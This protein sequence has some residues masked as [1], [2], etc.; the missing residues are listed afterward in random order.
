M[1]E[2]K[3]PWPRDDEPSGPRRSTPGQGQQCLIYMLGRADRFADS[4]VPGYGQISAGLGPSPNEDFANTIWPVIV[5]V[6]P[7]VTED[8][9]I[10]HLRDLADAIEQHTEKYRNRPMIDIKLTETNFFTRHHCTVCGGCTEKVAILAE[11]TQRLSDDGETR[12]VRVCETC[13]NDDHG[14]DALLEYHAGA[15][16]AEATL[17]RNLIGQLKAPTFAEWCKAEREYEV[18]AVMETTGTSRDEAESKVHPDYPRA[19][20]RSLFDG[21]GEDCPF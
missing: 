8:D 3:V 18:R 4:V 11:G 19:P 16:E 13:L 10:Q 1:N 5:K 7:A 17:I 15:L 12:I 9:L 21:N 14:I 2:T 20:N 6:K